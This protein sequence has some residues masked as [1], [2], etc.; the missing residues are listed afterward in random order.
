MFRVASTTVPGLPLSDAGWEDDENHPRMPPSWSTP[1][2]RRGRCRGVPRPLD[3]AGPRRVCSKR[4]ADRLKRGL[5]HLALIEH[6]LQH[7]TEIAV[8][9]RQN[10]LNTIEL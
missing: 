4:G 3:G 7:G 9:L 1:W 8:I 2:R 5:G 10:G 6:E